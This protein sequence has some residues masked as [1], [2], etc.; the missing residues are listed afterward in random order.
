MLD[1]V[2]TVVPV[3]ILY[4]I[5]SYTHDHSVE[6]MINCTFMQK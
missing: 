5:N 3:L 4:T 6:F 2:A 1:S